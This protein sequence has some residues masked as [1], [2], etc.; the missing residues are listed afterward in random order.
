MATLRPWSRSSRA[1]FSTTGVLPV[2]PTV[3]LPMAMTCTPRVESRRMRDVVEE[4]AGLDGDLEELRAA[5]EQAAHERARAPRR[6]SRMTSRRKVSTV[7]VQARSRSRIWG[8]CAKR[9]QPGQAEGGGQAA[10]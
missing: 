1:N 3:R 9:A 2:P 5:V 8:Q 10:G 6:S 7:S 4:A